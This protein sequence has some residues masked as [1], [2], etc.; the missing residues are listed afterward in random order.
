MSNFEDSLYG[1]EG[2]LSLTKAVEDVSQ[3]GYAQTEA[4]KERQKTLSALQE[5]LS[6]VEKKSEEAEKQLT[7]TARELLIQ[8]GEVAL[9]EQRT[10]VLRDRCASIRADNTELLHHI[11]KEEEKARMA[12]VRFTAYREKMEAHRRAVWRAASQTEGFKELEEKRALVRRLKQ[13]KEELTED[14]KNPSGSTVQRAKR[15]TDAL[16][17]EVA[18]TRRAVAERREQLQRE[19]ETHTQMKKHIEIGNKRYDA[20]IKRLRCQLSKAQAVHRQTSEDVFLLGG[21]D[22]RAE[23]AAGLVGQ[24]TAAFP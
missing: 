17:G 22:R 18:A 5:T 12:L 3:H 15:E 13:T 6:D 23:A 21:E 10:R 8:E 19:T 9:L 2:Q 14:L 7:S 16:R 24:M 4:L 11:S 20:I 1:P